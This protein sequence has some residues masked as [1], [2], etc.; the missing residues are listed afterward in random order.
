M[1]LRIVEWVVLGALSAACTTHTTINEPAA[2]TTT[3][4]TAGE[5]AADVGAAAC[6]RFQQCDA[7]DFSNAY[8]S[9]ANCIESFTSILFM[10]APGATSS[11][12]LDCTTAELDACTDAVVTL[13]CSNQSS[14]P[15][16]PSACAP[17]GQ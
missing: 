11:T 3:L 7:T 15:A 12:P 17:C 9:V 14:M 8:S 5:L 16:L 6:S 4:A 1:E 13:A 10:G 2:S